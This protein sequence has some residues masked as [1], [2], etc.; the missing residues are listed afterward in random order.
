[1]T[2]QT[3][4]DWTVTTKTE[5]SD[6]LTRRPRHRCP[7]GPPRAT[8]QGPHYRTVARLPGRSVA[9]CR[10]RT[11]GAPDGRT[12]DFTRGFVMKLLDHHGTTYSEFVE[13]DDREGTEATA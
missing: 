5:L 9:V 12:D 8:S 10:Q 7:L 13:A 3:P 2:T 4:P 11:V 1:M 6:F